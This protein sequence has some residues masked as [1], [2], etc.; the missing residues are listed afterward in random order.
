M[1]IDATPN[2]R[3]GESLD[4]ALHAVQ[5]LIVNK[6]FHS[7]QDAV[8]VVIHGTED[9]RHGVA[10]DPDTVDGQYPNI[11]E[12]QKM[13]P[14]SCKTLASLASVVS[15]A[16]HSADLV[17]TLCV[18]MFAVMQFV[19]QLKYT[20]RVLIITDGT[21]RCCVS[22]EQL[23]DI[24]KQIRESGLKL[25]VFGIGFDTASQDEYEAAAEDE[26]PDVDDGN[27]E[28]GGSMSDRLIAARRARTC[29]FL[30]ALSED[31]DK[32]NY[33]FTRLSDAVSMI[34]ALQ[35]RSVR[36]NT[37][38]RGA[39]AIGESLGVP[40]WT[41]KKVVP[42]TAPTMKPVSKTGLEVLERGA[43]PTT[44]VR[45]EERYYLQSEREEDIP[46]QLTVKGYRFGKDLVPCTGF[47]AERI[48]YGVDSKL[49]QLV[50][51]MPQAEL[52]RH[53]LVGAA[54][55]V[56]SDPESVGEP[57]YKALQAL[58]LV[59]E[60][61][62]LLAIARYAPRK[63]A[64]PRLVSL[65]P[66]I[67][68][69]W[70]LGIPFAD[71]LKRFDWGPP[72]SVPPPTAEQLAAAN[73]LVDAMDL[74]RADEGGGAETLVPKQVFNPKLRRY[75]Q[76]IAAR[77]LAMLRGG[78]KGEGGEGSAGGM[79]GDDR[80]GEGRGD[81]AGHG[82][83]AAAS[84]LPAPDWR[85]T[86]P[87]VQDETLLARAAP[88]LDAFAA[89]CPVGAPGQAGKRGR[90]GGGGGGGRAN[91]AA[92]TGDDG[93][94]GS[95]K[96]SRS[97][98]FGASAAGSGGGMDVSMALTAV[99]P[100]EIDSGDVIGS[101]WVMLGDEQVDRTAAAMRGMGEAILSYL[102][103]CHHASDPMAE[104]AYRALREFRRG[105]LMHEE[106]E[107]FNEALVLIKKAHST[108][109][110]WQRI[111]GDT[112]LRGGLI[113][114]RECEESTV[115]EGEAARFWSAAAEAPAAEPP[116]MARTAQDDD[117]DAFEGL[118]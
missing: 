103:A 7:K 25:E 51:V 105:A 19:R 61:E 40:V 24:S 35:K 106:V 98:P 28:H 6:I 5:Q 12:V 37:T 108:R 26:D 63:G 81:D 110:I 45:K 70:M 3:H 9:T 107:Q 85:V 38:F 50:G 17:D 79:G 65:W 47:E 75:N 23:Q 1:C 92:G 33:S 102:S 39:L 41:Y 78:E 69:F 117:D 27:E 49:L 89:A 97:D 42:A 10:D 20:K 88:A 59:L 46:P 71:E 99:V 115:D 60:E 18:G 56:F 68:S 36:S 4:Q 82:A 57:A 30:Q 112:E 96:R 93:L 94:R 104:K 72:P 44:T 114:S 116:P 90:G 118:D 67:R 113:T 76:C 86:M 64:A 29:I 62:G 66:A 53:M 80:D 109:D 73:D 111:L 31:L 101:F 83:A 43:D 77:A 100:S 34:E 84:L 14:V 13:G 87:L 2:V 58:L 11:T 8:G 32:E 48:K 74:S 21:S 55:C 15:I 95:D 16:P 54:E 52:P 91:G 22:D